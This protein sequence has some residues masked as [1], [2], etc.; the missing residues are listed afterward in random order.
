MN[1][2]KKKKKP[3]QFDEV[4]MHFHRV[5]KYIT[6]HTISNQ[7]GLYIT[8]TFTC[9]P[10]LKETP[11]ITLCKGWYNFTIKLCVCCIYF[12][13]LVTAVMSNYNGGKENVGIG[14]DN[15]EVSGK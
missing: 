6:R 2:K 12:Q 8:I 9:L 4:F 5:D 15:I 14:L 11:K 13:V 1:T 10:I 7:L 3:E